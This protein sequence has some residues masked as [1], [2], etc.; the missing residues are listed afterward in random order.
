[1][2]VY[3]CDRLEATAVAC[4]RASRLPFMSTYFEMS[5]LGD[6]SHVL[7]KPEIEQAGFTKSP[8]CVSFSQN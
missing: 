7:G 1:M 2:C 5:L 4:W 3:V 6:V 8:K